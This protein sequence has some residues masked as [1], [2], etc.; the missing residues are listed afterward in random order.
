[1]SVPGAAN[2]LLL[3]SAA[4][5]G[6]VAATERSVRFNSGDS[7]YLTRTP[8]TSGTRNKWTWSGWVKRTKQGEFHELFGAGLSGT[9][10]FALRFNNTDNLEVFDRTSSG[11]VGQITTTAVYRD[12]SAWY[13]I[14]YVWDTLNATGADRRRLYVNGIRVT[15]F[16]VNDIPS[17]G[18]QSRINS[19]GMPHTI[20]RYDPTAT[21]YLNGFLAE[22]HFLDGLAP[23]TATDDP[24]GSVTGIPNAQYLTDFGE[25]DA[26]TG[27]WNPKAYTGSYGTTTGFYLDFADNSSAAALG[28]DAVGSNDWTVKNISI[29]NGPALPG[30]AFDGSGDYLSF[31][32]GLTDLN[33]GTGDFTIECYAFTH[34]ASRAYVNLHV[35]N[36]EYQWFGL[37][38]SSYN[39]ILSPPNIPGSGNTS[40]S[41]TDV[42][43]SPNQWNHVA[44]TRSGNTLRVFING[45]ASASTYDVTGYDH[46]QSFAYIGV[47]NYLTYASPD[48]YYWFYGYMSNLRVVKGTALY[49]SSFTPPVTPLTAVTNTVL[50]CCQSSSST[51]TAAVTPGTITANGDVYA[52]TFS[53]QSGSDSLRD[54]PING[55]TAG[56]NGLGGE[57]PG[58]YCTWNSAANALDATLSNGNLDIAYGS[59]S[60]NAQQG[61]IGM[62]SGKWYWEFVVT[63]CSNGSPSPVMIGIADSPDP[64]TVAT[65]TGANTRGWAYYGG[66]GGTYHG[67][68]PAAYG[69]TWGIGDVVG[70][71]FDADNGSLYFYKNGT[72]QNS[73]TAAF[74]GLT[75]GPYFPSI[76]DASAGGTFSGTTNWGQRAFSHPAPSGFKALCTAN[77]T[78]PTIADPSTVMGVGLYQGN[79]TSKSITLPRSGFAPDFV[80]IKGRSI[81]SYGG[82]YDKLRG[83]RNG[84]ITALT[85]AEYGAAPAGKEL[86]SFDSTGFTVGADFNILVNTSPDTFSGW[87]WDAG[88]STAT[89]NDGS[90]SSQVRANVS[91]GFSIVTVSPSGTADTFGHGLGVA[92][93]LIISKRRDG[94]SAWYVRT[95]F[96]SNPGAHYLML[97]ATNTVAN[98]FTAWANT[99][100][101]SSVITVNASYLY[102]GLCDLV[103]YCFA[104]VNSYSAFGTYTGNGSA[105]GPFIYTGMRPRWIM[106]KASSRLSSWYIHDTQRGTYNV[107]G[108]V[109]AANTPASE[110]T[111]TRLD[112]LSN[113]FK[114]RDNDTEYNA[115]SDTYIY[116]AFAENPFAYARAR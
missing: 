116:A 12:P 18:A 59:G 76:G 7:A 45:V 74:T 104:S 67:G 78:P 101:N 49:T 56:D 46:S 8:P 102:G 69:N 3:S 94:A 80:W 61:T 115:L 86:T 48:F 95:S 75:N 70:I 73:G 89:N 90:V 5:G 26:V 54:S 27:V 39:A 100:A 23:G 35:G 16:D 92:P 15:A 40:F 103:H 112:I 87:C 29:D 106:T 42:L 9:D 105:N 33:L 14:V 93:A 111:P 60:R 55:D 19:G 88:S 68:T 31:A 13:H 85:N 43:T 53:S 11:N 22:I 77:L 28:Y 10:Y 21:L 62:T 24:S 97:N 72:V 34:S 52:S 79:G 47:A 37:L 65:Y 38:G 30:V 96:L 57:V 108:P 2:P 32:E 41:P 81:A 64:A 6:G 58:N 1:M 83:E 66:S 114:I 98:D 17:S 107:I 99:P 50:L 109:L 63:A 71:A 4:G 110:I 44:F 51:T 91:A 25:F 84:M 82:V 113:G 20:G 36:T